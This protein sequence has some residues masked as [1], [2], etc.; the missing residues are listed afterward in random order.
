MHTDNLRKLALET[1]DGVLCGPALAAADEI[2]L[3]RAE[4]NRMTNDR[5]SLIQAAK[6]VGVSFHKA[7][8]RAE[9]A[10]TERADLRAALAAM[11]ASPCPASGGAESV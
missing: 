3:L 1:N 6:D 4:I 8:A 9:K 2:D 7:L 11:E 5:V 10:E